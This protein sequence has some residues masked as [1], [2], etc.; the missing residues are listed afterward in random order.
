VAEGQAGLTSRRSAA[1]SRSEAAWFEAMLRT[2][3]IAP[4]LAIAATLTSAFAQT[5]ATQDSKAVDDEIVV[6]ADADQS[7]IDRQTY[8]LRQDAAAQ[9]TNMFDVL[10]RIPSVSVAPSGAV[11]LLGAANVTIQINGQP[12][13]GANL[14]QVRR[15]LAS[16]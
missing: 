6:L 11:T 14:E 10:G 3:H 5:P 15:L 4:A 2:V 16:R 8:T 7:R 9:S 1:I 12:V 13:P